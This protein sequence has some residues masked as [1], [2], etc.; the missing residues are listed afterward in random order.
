[1]PAMFDTRHH[2]ALRGTVA[3]E[4]VRDHHPWRPALPLQQLTQQALGCPLV[5]SALHQGIKDEPG[6]ARQ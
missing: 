5:T 4:L 6:A 1:M 2:L 3:R